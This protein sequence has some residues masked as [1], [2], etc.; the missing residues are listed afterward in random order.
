[1]Y[2]ACLD[3]E[4][5]SLVWIA[6]VGPRNTLFALDVRVHFFNKCL[7]FAKKS[8]TT[9]LIINNEYV[10][11]IFL[12]NKGNNKEVCWINNFQD[13]LNCVTLRNHKNE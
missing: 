6:S 3:I 5:V 4:P 1:M 9:P 8:L 13:I 12:K 10:G 7:L 2:F 11:R